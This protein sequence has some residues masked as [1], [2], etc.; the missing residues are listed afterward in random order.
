VQ[1]F[2]ASRF[3]ATGGRLATDHGRA[4]Y[5]NWGDPGHRLEVPSLRVAQSGAYLLQV[6]AANGSGG[7][8]TGITCAVKRVQVIE[9]VGGRTVA[10]GYVVMPQLGS[11]NEWRDST[12]VRASLEAGRD[13]RVVIGDDDAAV[14][15]SAFEHF[16]RYTGGMGGAGGA[17]FRVNIAALKVLHLGPA[18]P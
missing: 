2:D 4:H 12:F 16:T 10:D 1:Q 14:N 17:F 11:W 6:T 9:V 13:Y 3:V 8:T 7:T 15:M 5:E 18:T